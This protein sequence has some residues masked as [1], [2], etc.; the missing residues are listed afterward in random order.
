[1][2]SPAEAQKRR[3]I[4]EECKSLQ[5][6]VH[7]SHLDKWKESRINERA[8]AVDMALGKA[9]AWANPPWETEKPVIYNF[10][11]FVASFRRVFDVPGRATSAAKQLMTIQ[12]GTR[13]VPEYHTLAVESIRKEVPS[14]YSKIITSKA[15]ELQ[16]RLNEI[17]YQIDYMVPKINVTHKDN[18]TNAG[19]SRVSIIDPKEKYCVGDYLLLRVEVFNYLGKKKTY[20]GDYLRARITTIEFGAGATG[21]IEDF[22]NGT[23]HVHFI[24]FWEGKI[25][26]SVLL[27]HPSEGISAL[28]NSRNA[29]YGHVD[30]TGKFTSQYHSAEIKCGFDLNK[31]EELC[32]YSDHRDEEYFYCIKPQNFS[33]DSLTEIK[34]WRTGNSKLSALQYSLFNRSN[35]GVE[36]PKDF[37]QLIVV[38]CNTVHHSEKTF[39]A[40][41]YILE[42]DFFLPSIIVFMTGSE[43]PLALKEFLSAS[44]PS[45]SKK[46]GFDK[47]VVPGKEETAI[48]KKNCNI[49]MKLEYP[50]GYVMKNVWNPSSCRMLTYNSMEEINKC[51]EGKFI[52][53]FGDSTLR[54][55]MMYFENKLK[56]MTLFNLYEDGWARQRLGLDLKRNM[57]ISWKR[58][59][60]PFISGSY[61]SC[62]EDRSIP[63]E[64]D[65]IGGH[66]QTVIV[67]NIGVHFRSYPIHHFIRRLINIHR[68][69]QR[70]FQRSPQTK[71]I[72]KTENTSEMEKNFET[73][74]DFHAYIHFLIMKIIFKDLNVGWVNGWDM[75]TA[76]NTNKIHP[77]EI[78]IQNEV[79]MLLTYIC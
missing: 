15:S 20:G 57:K 65:L 78:L 32:E 58:H 1:M 23:Y 76:F 28:W 37:Q 54:M 42:V 74:S 25:D 13:T 2:F 40:L 24:L 52:Y 12:E 16:I 11:E 19:K 29:W 62:R 36:I 43:S 4:Q 41:Q 73:M 5:Q 61:H 59:N 51:M 47:E 17:F 53:M 38:D 9:L 44:R 55:W 69:L 48:V 39:H 46:L 77:P 31:S 79:N 67:I 18:T 27:M 26:V 64:I 68:A 34:S 33:C 45:A 72:I 14:T 71:V 30:Y 3:R 50:S 60:N 49:G 8:S 22:N 56:T 10:T 63:R 75:T 7:A 66:K 6:E 21:R 70:L 35:V